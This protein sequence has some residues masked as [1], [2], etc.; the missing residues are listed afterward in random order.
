MIIAMTI[1]KS[2]QLDFLRHLFFFSISCIVKIVQ[3]IANLHSLVFFH[4]FD[5]PYY[6]FTYYYKK[7][8]FF[9]WDGFCFLFFCFKWII[10]WKNQRIWSP[11]CMFQIL[12]IG[13]FWSD[14]SLKR[15][16]FFLFAFIS[17]IFPSSTLR[18][19]YM[20]GLVSL[21]FCSCVV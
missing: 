9:I 1:E 2:T 10:V 18:Y 3:S 13:N 8:Y 12:K 20:F 21:R 11:F 19:S 6:Y 7:E 4:I 16:F 17:R 5:F 14:V 15:F